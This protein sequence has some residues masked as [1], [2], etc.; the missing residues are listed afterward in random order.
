MLYRDP[1]TAKCQG[2][3]MKMC[4]PYGVVVVVVVVVKTTEEMIWL[5]IPL[6]ID[7][8]LKIRN[9]ELIYNT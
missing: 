7:T 4:N 3:D 5:A 2:V 8:V 9:P 1:E 6:I